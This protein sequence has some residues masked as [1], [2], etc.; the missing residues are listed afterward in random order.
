MQTGRTSSLIPELHGLQQ[1]RQQHGGGAASPGGHPS[2]CRRPRP[3]HRARRR[4]AAMVPPPSEHWPSR[5]PARVAACARL[6]RAPAALHTDAGRVQVQPR[7]P[8]GEHPGPGGWHAADG[9]LRLLP[10]ATTQA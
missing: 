10:D 2:N 9:S 4:I 1:R 5:R 6:A 3:T 7:A 8:A